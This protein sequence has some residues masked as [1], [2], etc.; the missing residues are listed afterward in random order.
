MKARTVV[1]LA[2]LAIVA[3]SV[4][5]LVAKEINRNGAAGK[6][7]GAAPSAAG[8]AGDK[9]MRIEK[10]GVVAFYVHRN[11]RCDACER[12]E[13]FSREAIT[14]GFGG[15]LKSGRL[16]FVVVNIDVRGNEHFVKELN[17]PSNGVFLAEYKEGRALR[18][19]YLD[20]VWD[21]QN[22]RERFVQYVQGELAAFLAEVQ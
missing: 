14:G 19:K 17:I 18:P 20:K 16:Q 15:E 13:R 3:A 10:D 2:L 11:A 12:M 8:G 9:V 5:V 21:F 7:E 1:G 22:D 6:P 4:A